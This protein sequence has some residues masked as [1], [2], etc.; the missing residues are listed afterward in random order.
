M[1]IHRRPA[2]VLV[3]GA[4]LAGTIGLSPALASASTATSTASSTTAAP[5]W[6]I[7]PGGSITGTAPSAAV[8]DTTNGN[9]LSCVGS[10]LTESLKSGSKL[11]GSNAGSLS[12]FSLTKC[13]ADGLF[14]SILAKRTP[15]H[16]SLSAYDATTGL[17][18]ITLTGI[19]L[20]VSQKALGCTAAV[21]GTSATADNGKIKMSY[22]SKT[23]DLTT[24]KTEGNLHL[25]DVSSNCLGVVNTGDKV[26]LTATY[27][28]SPAQKITSP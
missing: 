18:T 28:A 9:K 21:D 22:S 8:T 2:V 3:A 24:F 15:W 11:P 1:A 20:A 13:G 14:I 19:H 5:T 12:K 16:V 25:Y 7:K 23:H 6:T 27:E 26:S 17:T 4:T 10:S